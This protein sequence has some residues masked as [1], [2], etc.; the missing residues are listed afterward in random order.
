VRQLSR[1]PL[2]GKINIMKVTFLLIILCGL[3]IGCN[4]VEN[5]LVL[6]NGTEQGPADS[7]AAIAFS[8]AN[9]FIKHER[10]LH[11]FI[12]TDPSIRKHGERYEVTYRLL[13]KSEESEAIVGV[14][15]KSRKC[16]RIK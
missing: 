8:L 7:D 1:V 16:T 4:P 2:G 5:K 6:K 9:E 13:E 12:I 3:F 11:R 10:D 15:I 14:D